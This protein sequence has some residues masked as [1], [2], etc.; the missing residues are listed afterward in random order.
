[1][2]Y[3]AFVKGVTAEFEAITPSS[4]Q[5]YQAVVRNR[6][7]PEEQEEVLLEFAVDYWALQRFG[8]MRRSTCPPIK[9]DDFPGTVQDI[10]DRTPSRL[11]STYTSND[12][13][14]RV[15]NL[16]PEGGGVGCSW[17]AKNKREQEVMGALQ[18]LDT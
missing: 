10:F 4:V 11:F 12:L 5:A 13:A 18:G 17:H 14:M 2:L 7:L 15:V 1:M 6:R 3:E 16:I 9:D 8:S